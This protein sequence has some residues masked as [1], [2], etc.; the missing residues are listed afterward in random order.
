MSNKPKINI[1][2]ALRELEIS[3]RFE[4]A[5]FTL[6]ELTYNLPLKASD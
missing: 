4:Q 6:T 3:Q 2:K 1:D 5:D